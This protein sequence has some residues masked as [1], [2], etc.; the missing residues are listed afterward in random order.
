MYVIR[1]GFN[2]QNSRKNDINTLSNLEAD[3]IT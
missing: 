3:T 2:Y 1:I